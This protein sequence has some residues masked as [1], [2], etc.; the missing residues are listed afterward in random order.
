MIATL[1]GVCETICSTLQKM[2]ASEASNKIFGT[3][4]KTLMRTKSKQDKNT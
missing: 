1:K 4:T 2:I 3:Q